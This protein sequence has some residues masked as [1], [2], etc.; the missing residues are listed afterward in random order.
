MRV[1][2]DG[3]TYIFL[4][5]DFDVRML[6]NM[7]DPKDRHSHYWR[8]QDGSSARWSG[9]KKILFSRLNLFIC[10]IQWK[11]HN[12]ITR[13][14]FKFLQWIFFQDFEHFPRDCW[15]CRSYPFCW[16]SGTCP[17]MIFRQMVIKNKAGILFM[18]F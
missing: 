9:S 17:S 1:Y 7:S 6:Q 8:G 15:T 13:T 4:P 12:L 10:K 5:M 2:S 14:S 18:Q 16:I 3:F 11:S